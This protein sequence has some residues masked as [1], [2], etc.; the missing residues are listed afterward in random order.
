MNSIFRT[1]KRNFR[2]MLF[3]VGLCVMLSHCKEDTEEVTDDDLKDFK[4]LPTQDEV[5]AHLHAKG[6][7]LYY[8]STADIAPNQSTLTDNMAKRYLTRKKWTSSDEPRQGDMFLFGAGEF[9]A[10]AANPQTFAAFKK[11]YDSGGVIFAMEG[12]YETDFSNVCKALGCY[13]PYGGMADTKYLP[14]EKPLWIFSGPLPSA[15]GIVMKLRPSDESVPPLPPAIAG[16]ANNGGTKTGFFNDYTQGQICDMAVGAIQQSLTPPAAANDPKELTALTQPW[17]FYFQLDWLTIKKERYHNDK[18]TDDR[19]AV[20]QVEYDV[21]FAFSED[22]GNHYYYIHAEIN[23][24]FSNYYVGTY[25]YGS[26]SLANGFFGSKITLHTGPSLTPEGVNYIRRS[27]GETHLNTF[28]S[29]TTGVDFSLPGTVSLKDRTITDGITI[30][31]S[32]SYT[33]SNVTIS[34]LE[35]KYYPVAW[36]IEFE[37]SHTAIDPLPPYVR[38]DPG[39]Q[40]GINTFNGGVDLIFSMPKGHDYTWFMYYTV[41]LNLVNTT[42]YNILRVDTDVEEQIYSQ[43]INLPIVK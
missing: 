3:T 16:I 26:K 1:L 31:K 32:Q 30:R 12:G 2:L 38:I 23:C 41:E 24:P 9:A 8:F 36:K 17:R 19:K 39:S 10:I 6:L 13:D 25:N 11:M 18:V 33:A 42:D 43:F 35:D 20:F 14:G 27:P 28:E 4:E 22:D 5:A 7:V 29:Y 21:Y 37:K 40:S 34:E 15:S